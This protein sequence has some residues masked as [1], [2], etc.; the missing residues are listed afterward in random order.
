[1]DSS[2][3][4]PES[5]ARPTRSGWAPADAR[6]WE[7]ALPNELPAL[8]LTGWIGSAGAAAIADI[9]VPEAWA[10]A[11]AATAPADAP[12]P[13]AAFVDLGDWIR[14]DEP[15]PT[16]RLTTDD[17]TPTGDEAA[18]FE[19]MLGVFKA[20]IARSVDATDHESHYDLGVA[21]REMGLVDE[22]IAE[23]QRAARAPASALRSREALG[24]CFLDR[25]SPD[26]AIGVLERALDEAT[27][28]ASAV[29]EVALLG[30]VYLLGEAYARIGQHKPARA[31]F[32]RVVAA[33]IEFRDA[34]RRLTQL[35]APTPTP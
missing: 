28:G 12:R 24:Q 14:A 7:T 13:A 8:S 29:D 22:A 33:D 25:G 20:G 10:T 4:L 5:A 3:K 19:R 21:F 32:Q 9:V 18:D 11:P 31:C 35:P 30:V 2:V 6:R 27:S 26:L 17:L 23:F 16:T 1:M 15:P 34:A